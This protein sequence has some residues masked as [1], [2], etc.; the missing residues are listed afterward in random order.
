MRSSGAVAKYVSRSGANSAMQAA[1]QRARHEPD[2]LD[3][4]QPPD[5]P[6]ERLAVAGLLEDRVVDD[7]LERPRLECE[8]HAEEDRGDHVGGDVLAE[9][10]DDDADDRRHRREDEDAAAAPS[11]GQHPGRQLQ[12][13][14]DD[15]VDGR[16]D[17]DRCRREADAR[18]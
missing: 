15:G 7:R 4:P 13:G 2:A 1:G 6:L 12:D 11:V 8:E 10:A 17:P 5:R 3:Q 14:D 18:S 16:H 9:A